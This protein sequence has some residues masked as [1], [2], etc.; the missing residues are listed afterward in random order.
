MIDRHGNGTVTNTVTS[1]VTRAIR[2]GTLPLGKPRRFSSR[3]TVSSVDRLAV[4]GH[5]PATLLLNMVAP[6]SVVSANCV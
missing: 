1:T 6:L 4:Y 3:S 5:R 2:E